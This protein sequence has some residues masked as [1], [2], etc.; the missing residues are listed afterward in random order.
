MSTYIVRPTTVGARSGAVDGTADSGSTWST[1]ISAAN[2]AT[3]TGDNS[4]LTAIRMGSAASYGQ[5]TLVLGAPSIAAGEFVARVG[6]LVRWSAGATGK[7]V[8]CTPF[9][10]GDSVPSGVSAVQTNGSVTRVTSEPG[11]TGTS[12]AAADVAQLLL[13]TY[14]DGA[15]TAGS[16]PIVWEWGATVYTL[17]NATATPT[18]TTMTSSV[19]ATIPVSVSATI[20]WEASTLDWQNLR[21]V[22]VQVQV[23]SGGTGVGTGSIV[24]TAT[25]DVLF[26]ATG[27]QTVNVTLANGLTNG[28]YKVYA[29]AIRYR[30]SGKTNIQ[31]DQYGSW[32]SSA[33]L[34]MNATPPTAPT[35]TVTKD[36]ANGRVSIVVTPVATTGYSSPTIK[37]QRA[38]DYYLGPISDV[39]GAVGVAGTFGSASTFYD[40]EAPIGSGPVYLVT[41]SA[42]NSGVV[43]T[44]SVVVAAVSG[45]ITTTTWNLKCPE[46][47]SLNIIDLQVLA[48]LSETLSEDVGVFRPL[49]RRYPVVVAGN[50]NG[51]DGELNVYCMTATD[52]ASLK[53]LLESQKVLRLDS[54]FGWS[55][56]IRVLSGAQANL[57][58]SATAPRR[59]VKLSYVQTDRP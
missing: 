30:E 22:T 39:R 53:A 46:N 56:Y 17:A 54:P 49:D 28:T 2:Q 15:T 24:G 3:Y 38:D 35:V 20:G 41:V 59:Q 33:T 12:W 44:S 13:R 26:T 4:D 25:A 6:G 45:Y 42:T 40:Y 58:G 27:S 55:K 11:Y 21:L 18:A 32:S 29:R 19:F 10:V 52:W 14:M 43:N 36:P 23:E 8:G 16:R 7:Y 34:T 48:D 47:S 50:L 9:R 37:I 5:S 51:W 1:S 31:S 57:L